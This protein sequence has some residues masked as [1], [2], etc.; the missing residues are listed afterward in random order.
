MPC[1]HEGVYVPL[2]S[3]YPTADQAHSWTQGCLGTAGRGQG[4][5]VEGSFRERGDPVNSS[6][7]IKK[8]RMRR[9][10]GYLREGPASKG[11]GPTLVLPPLSRQPTSQA[12][13]RFGRAPDVGHCPQVRW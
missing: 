8:Q 5:E 10:Q 1:P 13:Q 6:L 3:H 7:N 9:S 4:R 11:L 12:R 2:L